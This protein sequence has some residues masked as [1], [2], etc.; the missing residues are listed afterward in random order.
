MKSIPIEPESLHQV[1]VD[2]ESDRL[3]PVVLGEFH[4]GKPKIHALDTSLHH[5]PY[6]IF[7]PVETSE[8]LSHAAAEST[9]II[10]AANTIEGRVRTARKA[11]HYKK[12]LVDAAILD[13]RDALGGH[14]LIR[15]P[16]TGDWSACPACLYSDPRRVKGSEGLLY[17]LV[18]SIA[19]IA[20]TLTIQ[21]ITSTNSAFLQRENFVAVD[22]QRFRVT[23]LAIEK[24]P[25]CR[26]CGPSRQ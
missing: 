19:A 21:L 4:V 14:I 25:S 22:L 1:S 13:G 5:R 24:K 9:V 26:I 11:I 17:P 18:A 20:A 2:G 12:P 16:E 3:Q 6:F 10:S 7:E 8:A 23:T 15:R